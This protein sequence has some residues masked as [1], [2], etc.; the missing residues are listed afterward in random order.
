MAETLIIPQNATREDIYIS[1]MPQLKA[2]VMGETDLIANVSNIT[3]ALKEAFGFF[4]IGFYFVKNDELVLGPFQG[5]IACTRIKKGR[6]VCGT[7][8]EKGEIIVVP[9]VDQFPGHIACSSLSRSE[10]VIPFFNTKNEIAGVIDIDSSLLNDFSEID[11]R[12]GEEIAKLVSSILS[13]NEN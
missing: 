10:I 8:W 7:S 5:P 13:S 11:A 2:L 9:D 1:L 12:F 6:G 4:W 3:A